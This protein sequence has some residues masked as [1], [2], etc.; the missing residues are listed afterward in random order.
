M[1]NFIQ[2]GIGGGGGW[3][4]RSY[5]SI[6]RWPSDPSIKAT[7]AHYCPANDGSFN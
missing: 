4:G 5:A 1:D 7:K 3:R 6:R 2:H